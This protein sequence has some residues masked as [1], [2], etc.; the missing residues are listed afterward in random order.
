MLQKLKEQ[1]HLLDKATRD[2]YNGDHVSALSIAVIVRT[3]V[4]KTAKS[5][6]LIEIIRADYAA[7]T[8]Q[9]KMPDEADAA[10]AAAEGGGFVVHCSIGI[11]VGAPGGFSPYVDL[12]SPGFKL[13]TLETWWT[14]SCLI[15]PIGPVAFPHPT[16]HAVFSKKE[17]TLIL[18]NKEGGAHVD[19]DLPEKY[20]ALV[21]DSPFKTFV[22]G[23]PTDTANLA[24]YAVGQA[25]I[26]LL[27][28]VQRVFFPRLFLPSSGHFNPEMRLWQHRACLPPESNWLL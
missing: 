3:L 18:A 19:V 24:R 27:E 11:R 14:R 5:T 13:V 16:Q 25:G 12:K 26:E 10:R 6:P 22:N 15:F 9:D 2:F 4:H 8:I 21:T 17:L 7:V 23:T 1:A 20:V 28:C